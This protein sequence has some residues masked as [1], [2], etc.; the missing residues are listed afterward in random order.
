MR[1]SS[2]LFL[3]FTVSKTFQLSQAFVQPCLSSSNVKH[4]PSYPLSR[5]QTY[6][7]NDSSEGSP[8]TRRAWIRSSSFSVGG[9]A[10][11]SWILVKPSHS[12][13]ADISVLCDPSVSTIRHG[14]R[15]IHI[16]GTAHISADS[17]Q[18]AYVSYCLLLHSFSNSIS[19]TTITWLGTLG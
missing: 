6:D 12:A 7:N 8:L 17:A 10:I 1:I 15:V 13:A 18:L 11:S 3:I 9:A 5:L 14:R 4:D 2:T 19:L 16:L